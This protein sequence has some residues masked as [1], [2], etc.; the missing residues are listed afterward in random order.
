MSTVLANLKFFIRDKREH[1]RQANSLP[2]LVARL[3]PTFNETHVLILRRIKVAKDSCCCPRDLDACTP[4][5]RPAGPL[6]MRPTS[7]WDLLPKRIKFSPNP[8]IRSKR[9]PLINQLERH[10]TLILLPWCHRIQDHRHTLKHKH[11]VLVRPGVPRVPDRHPQRHR[12]KHNRNA[13]T[14]DCGNTSEFHESEPTS[15]N[16]ST[17]KD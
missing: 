12:R 6:N 2:H 17:T 13:N 9:L 3:T 8:N 14:R 4:H 11:R 1:I 5:D 7:R 16:V 10:L 15:K